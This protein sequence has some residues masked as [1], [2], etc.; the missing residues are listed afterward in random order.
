LILSIDGVSIKFSLAVSD[1]ILLANN[2]M[3]FILHQKLFGVLKSRIENALTLGFTIL[4]VSIFL[5][6]H[7]QGSS[8]RYQLSLVSLALAVLLCTAKS[9]LHYGK[10]SSFL[11]NEVCARVII[12]ARKFIFSLTS[13]NLSAFMLLLLTRS[14]INTRAL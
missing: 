7:R 9:S 1:S 8:Q 3:R 12:T 11:R 14:T 2:P 4:F 6:H 5:R 10:V 13:L